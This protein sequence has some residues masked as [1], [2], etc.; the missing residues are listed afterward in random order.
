M[1]ITQKLEKL[2]NFS[3][4]ISSLNLFQKEENLDY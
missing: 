2:Y 3:K 4:L 1:K